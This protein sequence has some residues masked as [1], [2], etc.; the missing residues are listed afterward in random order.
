MCRC[1]AFPLLAASLLALLIQSS[2]CSRTW[3]VG[4]GG[5]LARV[6]DAC[7][8][9]ASSDTIAILPGT[10]DEWD[11]Y[12]EVRNKSLSLIGQGAEPTD[13]T[14]LVRLFFNECEG[15]V[16]KSLT[17]GPC[18]APL[19]F[20][21][22]SG[23]VSDCEFRGCT[24]KT[25]Y[26]WGCRLTIEDCVFVGNSAEDLGGAFEGSAE[27]I[28]RC[29]FIENSAPMAGAVYLPGGIPSGSTIW[30]EDCIFLRNSA[31]K[32][33]ALVTFG[34]VSVRGNTFY[35]NVVTGL[36]GDGG[37]FCVDTGDWYGSIWNNIFA[38][39]IGGVGVE[40]YSAAS[41]HC[42]DFW[43]NEK[44][45]ASGVA[46]IYESWGDI[47]LDPMFCDPEQGDFGLQE[48]SPCLPG[49]HGGV[50]CELMG[51][52]DMGCGFSATEETSWGKIRGM[53]R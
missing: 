21:H 5:D 6:V 28:L 9:A 39:T 44:G 2:A 13:V 19:G 37:A 11:T 43:N 53:F 33:A 34:H 27:A 10:Y 51:A 7:A 36:G 24:E 1:S 31:E 8:A 14:L 15:T 20:Q 38:G 49:E 52:R 47:F 40:C 3:V 48:G 12:T 26:S 42:C 50:S 30:I 41:F 22:G 18:G 29:V 4:G 25:M 46:G 32:G 23:V 16:V 35:G 17:F 45:V